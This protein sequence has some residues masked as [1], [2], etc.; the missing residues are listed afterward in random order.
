MNTVHNVRL[1]DE[2]GDC[3]V[4]VQSMLL[5]RWILVHSQEHSKQFGMRVGANIL[6]T[7]ETERFEVISEKYL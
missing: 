6:G 4:P 5:L 3:D 7:K 2:L 1:C